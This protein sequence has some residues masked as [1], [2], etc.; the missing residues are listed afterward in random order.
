MFRSRGIL[1]KVFLYPAAI[2]T[3]ELT[4]HNDLIGG[5][6]ACGLVV[7]SHRCNMT[8]KRRRIGVQQE[9][10]EAEAS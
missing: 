7:P 1:R 6:I 4:H 8:V 10:N 9:E 2:L 5:H 3:L